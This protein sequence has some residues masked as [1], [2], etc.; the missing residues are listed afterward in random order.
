MIHAKTAPAGSPHLARLT[1]LLFVA[2]ALVGSVAALAVNVNTR[3]E[4]SVKK[5]GEDAAAIHQHLRNC[6]PDEVWKTRSHKRPN[7]FYLGCELEDDCWGLCIT[8]FVKGELREIT[9]F[10]VKDGTRA[11]FIEYVSARATLVRQGV[12]GLLGLLP[13]LLL[14]SL[15]S[16]LAIVRRR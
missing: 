11:Q 8:K 2:A 13:C 10:I 3:P 14:P 9:S 12:S 4:H 15:L 6:D 5:H 7:V 1:L 16:L